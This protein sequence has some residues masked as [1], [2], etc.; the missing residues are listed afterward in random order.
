MKLVMVGSESNPYIKTGGLADVVFALSRQMAKTGEEVS[1]FLPLYS[2]VKGKLKAFEK[3]A[4]VTVYLGWRR[5]IANIY[6][7]KNQGINF[8]FVENQHYFERGTIYGYD[9]DGERFAFY[10]QAVIETLKTLN[11]KPDIIHVHDWQSAMIPC[12]IKEK[13][14]PFFEGT[15]FVLTIHNPAF[16]GIIY[17]ESIGDL[18]NL[19]DYLFTNGSLRF[20]DVVS[21]LKGGIIYADKITTV[22]P[23]H[24]NELLTRE[25]GMGLDATLALREYDFCGF[26]NGIGYE[27]F[28]P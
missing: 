24:R 5:E 14:D 28:N 19:P 21:T 26:L 15:K 1:I 9:D 11:Y 13:H 7:E 2:G 4:E 16:Q 10:Q 20:G 3:V 25:G 22:S 12:L 8:L 18:Y 27:E 6:L 23:T 17:R